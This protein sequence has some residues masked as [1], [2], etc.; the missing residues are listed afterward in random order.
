VSDKTQRWSLRYDFF[1][2]QWPA[3]LWFL[4]PPIIWAFRSLPSLTNRMRI[5][6]RGLN[7]PAME[8][9]TRAA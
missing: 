3:S 8:F 5:A 1:S 2:R 9:P 6:D 7:L 4:R